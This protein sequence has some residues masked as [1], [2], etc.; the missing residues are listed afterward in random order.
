MDTKKI[1]ASI[2]FAENHVHKITEELLDEHDLLRH[3]SP[4][5]VRICMDSRRMN[6]PYFMK[7]TINTEFVSFEQEICGYTFRKI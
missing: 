3:S 5:E 1:V 6:C 7:I 2:S 4:M